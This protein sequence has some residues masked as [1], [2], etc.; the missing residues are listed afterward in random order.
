M[1]RIRYPQSDLKGSQPFS[2]LLPKKKTRVSAEARFRN[3]QIQLL[4][5][6]YQE[7][8][9][10]NSNL[11]VAGQVISPRTHDDSDDELESYE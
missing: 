2:R 8:Q 10:V 5:L 7:L 6:I 11:A 9:K 4:N 3:D 1:Y